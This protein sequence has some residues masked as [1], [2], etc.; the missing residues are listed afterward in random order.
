MTNTECCHLLVRRHRVLLPA[1]GPS[2][3]LLQDWPFWTFSFCCF[4]HSSAERLVFMGPL[5]SHVT[6]CWVRYRYLFVQ[7]R[8]HLSN[9]GGKLSNSCFL[10]TSLPSTPF[11][12]AVVLMMD[13]WSLVSVTAIEAFSFLKL[14]C[15][16]L[17]YFHFRISGACRNQSWLWKS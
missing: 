10:F 4:T 15:C 7:L 16:W 5:F 14:K 6:F 9:N 3:V 11:V 13:S 2:T 8:I 12:F 1:S 17:N